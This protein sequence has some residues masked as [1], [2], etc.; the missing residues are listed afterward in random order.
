LI[1]VV[2]YRDKLFHFVCLFIFVEFL[3]Q[4][5]HRIFLVGVHVSGNINCLIYTFIKRQRRW[6]FDCVF[7]CS[8]DAVNA[9]MAIRMANDTI[10]KSNYAQEPLSFKI[11][12]LFLF[13]LPWPLLFF[14]IDYFPPP[15]RQ[16]GHHFLPYK[17]P[18]Q[19]TAAVSKWEHWLALLFS[20]THQLFIQMFR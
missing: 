4:T 9:G 3:L 11:R 2:S 19:I 14:G 16:L 12:D 17:L 1:Y 7:T 13:L 8:T 15:F 20:D 6:M 5:R 18:R 10:N